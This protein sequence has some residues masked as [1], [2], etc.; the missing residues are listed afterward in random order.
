[1]SNYTT[2]AD[3][4]GRLTMVTAELD[5][6]LLSAIDAAET[7]IEDY[8]GERVFTADL[9]AT[10]RV[11][12]P[13]GGHVFVDDISSTTGLVVADTGQ[14]YSTYQLEPVNALAKGRP[15]TAV[16][17]LGGCFAQAYCEEASVTVTARWGWPSVPTPV[18]NA[19][20]ILA[21]D[22]FNMRDNQFGVAG[23]GDM[24]VMRIRENAQVKNLLVNYRRAFAMR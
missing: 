15:L 14:T 2:F 17:L 21:A 16:R 22:L 19:T 7:A 10:A 4:R 1:M 13:R 5:A 12:V 20:E 6:V 11:F 24:G 8:C 3:M 23:F 9:A 18:K